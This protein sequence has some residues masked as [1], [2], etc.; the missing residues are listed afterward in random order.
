[1]SGFCSPSAAFIKLA[2]ASSA[3]SMISGCQVSTESSTPSS[4]IVWI[5]PSRRS[6]SCSSST[7]AAN[8]V[9]PAPP[10]SIPTHPCSIN[11]SARVRAASTVSAIEKSA[12]ESGEAL[13]T[14]WSFM[15]RCPLS[16][17][18]LEAA[19]A[20][21]GYAPGPPTEESN[22]HHPSLI[23]GTGLAQTGEYARK[24]W[25]L[26]K[27]IRYWPSGHNSAQRPTGARN[28]VTP[29]SDSP[30]WR[31]S[32]DSSQASMMHGAGS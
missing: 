8:W 22:R 21:G 18:K 4:A 5:L 2:P 30:W 14:P 16:A 32:L 26:L 29:S 23:I 11:S 7:R 10:R 28:S 1:M 13:M 27:K 9:E 31:S 24:L 12:S 15:G 25:A 19:I 17:T 20:D 3:R 6:H